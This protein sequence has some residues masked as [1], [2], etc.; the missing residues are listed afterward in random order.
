MLQAGRIGIDETKAAAITGRHLG[1]RHARA[2]HGADRRGAADAKRATHPRVVPGGHGQRQPGR[3]DD[4]TD[5]TGFFNTEYFV[6]NA[7][8]G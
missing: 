5:V 2:Q 1:A 7:D 6:E 3:P 4:G 8:A